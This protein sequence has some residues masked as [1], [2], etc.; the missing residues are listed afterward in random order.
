ADFTFAWPSA[1]ISSVAPKTAAEILYG[2]EFDETETILQNEDDKINKYI[3]ENASAFKA[4]ENCF[5]D[6]VI[7]PDNT[8]IEII[9]ALE[10]LDGKR[11][12]NLSRKLGNI[13]I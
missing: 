4:A 13:K 11:V 5:I 1:V 7:V 10:I 12:V 3:N 6:N 9:K 8:R 2:D